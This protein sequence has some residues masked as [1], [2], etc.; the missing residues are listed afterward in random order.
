[1]EAAIALFGPRPERRRGHWVWR[2]APLVR[3]VGLAHRITVVFS[4]SA[5]FLMRLERHFPELS[6]FLEKSPA[7]EIRWPSVGNG[8]C[9]C[10]SRHNHLG[11]EAADAGIGG[12][13]FDG[14]EKGFDVAVDLLVDA[15][16]GRV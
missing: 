3:E 2:Y 10:R 1:M 16:N 6:S 4:E 8:S 15:G 11:P 13:H 14:G 9:R 7:Q 5:P 12:R